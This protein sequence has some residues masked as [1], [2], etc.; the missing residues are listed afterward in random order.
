MSH[1]GGCLV[2]RSTSRRSTCRAVAARRRMTCAL[3]T[4]RARRRRKGP[5]PGRGARGKL[6]DV[7]SIS[8]HPAGPVGRAVPGRHEG[9]PPRAGREGL[10]RDDRGAHHPFHAP[11]APADRP[12]GPHRARRDRVEDRRAPRTSPPV[13]RMGLGQGDGRARGLQ[14]RD[15][16]RRVLLRPA[17]TLTA[18]HE[19]EQERVAPAI[20]APQ[21]RPR[22]RHRN[23]LN[24][25]AAE[26]NERPGETLAWHTPAEKLNELLA[27]TG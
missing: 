12:Q 15:R 19:R 3:R 25:M 1:T 18:R 23:P 4:G 10:G 22:Y 8:E 24:Q 20:P 13:A 2:R 16:H 6:K 9:A 14:G 17:V 7:E 26:L 11:R 21:H 5:N 27:M